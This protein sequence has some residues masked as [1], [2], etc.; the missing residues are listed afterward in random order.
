MVTSSLNYIEYKKKDK[1]GEWLEV[2]KY[3]EGGFGRVYFCYCH[4]RH[5]KVVV[6]TLRRRIWVGHRLKNSWEEFN[7]KLLNDS[8][9]EHELI[10]I[11]D[12]IL[13]IFFREARITCQMQGHPNVINGINFWWNEIGQIF[14]ECEY[15]ADSCDLEVLYKRIEEKTSKPKLSVLEAIHIG[16]SFCNG[17]LYIQHEVIPDYNKNIKSESDKASFFVHRDIKPKNILINQKNRIKIIDL[18]LS[19]YITKA[20]TVSQVLTTPPKAGTEAYKS[21]EQSKNFDIVSSSSD[22]Y[23]FGITLYELL[24][25]SVDFFLTRQERDQLPKLPEI[26]QPFMQILEKCLAWRIYD[27]Y[28]NFMEL[29]NDLIKFLLDAQ[30]NSISINENQRCATCGMVH[31]TPE[32]H[33]ISPELLKDMEVS[34]GEND[35]RFIRISGSNFLTG[36]KPDD[37]RILLPKIQKYYKIP[38]LNPPESVYLPAFEIDI[39]PVTNQQY[40][41]FVKAVRYPMPTHWER[42][43]GQPFPIE[44]SNHPVVNVSFE[45]ALAYCNWLKYRLP[46]GQEWEKAARGTNGNIYPWGN[47]YD[48]AKCNCYESD[49]GDTLPVDA[50]ENGKS[51]YGC[52]QMTGN[53][54]EWVNESHEQSDDFKNIRGGNWS[55]S[56]DFIG[57]TF[58]NSRFLRMNAAEDTVGFRVVREVQTYDNESS[59]TKMGE[60]TR[61]CCVL[62]GGELMPFQLK[63][64]NI[65]E[66]NIYTWNGYFDIE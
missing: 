43:T 6:K 34:I 28:Q 8:L 1:I 39:F 65:P 55:E 49:H 15:Y 18:G 64:I 10:N 60:D 62:C 35:H 3:E 36:C 29:K 9:P 2:K 19:K 58:W 66:K 26:S 59:A 57:I 13:F 52:F 25:G 53:V 33:A 38:E 50:Y 42:G 16:V 54:A 27:R 61:E 24:G 44:K 40:Y 31:N 37:T 20:K 11:G 22:I 63:D 41:N 48:I 21:P 56:C 12:Y 30:Q 14:L 45:D 47:D 51:P 7:E 17:M 32:A 4:K 5:R 46:S 23:S